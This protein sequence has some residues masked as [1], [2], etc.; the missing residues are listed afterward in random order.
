MA[1][2][3]Y[4]PL[5]D[6]RWLATVHTTGPW[7]SRTQH[8]GPPSALLG[9]AMQECER[10]PDMMIARFTCEIL[11]P[12]P[13]GEISVAARAVRRGRSVELLEASATKRGCPR[14]P[15]PARRR[16]RV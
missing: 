6:G 13:V 7:D 14:L 12:V 9:R 11:R 4:V 2:S 8:G 15:S 1:D 16:C 3:F 5:G 10:R